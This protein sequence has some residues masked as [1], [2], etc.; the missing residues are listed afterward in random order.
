MRVLRF[1]QRCNWGFTSFRMWRCVDFFFFF[2]GPTLRQR[3][4]T[5]I[6]RFLFKFLVWKTESVQHAWKFFHNSSRPSLRSI[7]WVTK[8]YQLN[9]KNLYFRIHWQVGL[10]QA[11]V[12]YR[13][14]ISMFCNSDAIFITLKN[15]WTC[16]LS[17]SPF[18]ARRRS[19]LLNVFPKIISNLLTFFTATLLQ[20]TA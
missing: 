11:L 1:S 19:S 2:L 5:W 16:I 14:L 8:Q 13:T 10:G 18:I 4:M 20:H 15:S 9:I 3:M 6:W 12:E 7:S 17:T